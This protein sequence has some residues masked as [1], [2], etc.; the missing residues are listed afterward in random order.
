MCGIRW[1]PLE[2]PPS[3]SSISTTTTSSEVTSLGSF[4]QEDKALDSVSDYE[5]NWE[6]E[7]WGDIQVGKSLLVRNRKYGMYTCTRTRS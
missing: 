6:S 3:S 7:N 5:E 4:E 2:Q 1:R